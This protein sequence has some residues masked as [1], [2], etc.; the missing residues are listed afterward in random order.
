MDREIEE[1]IFTPDDIMQLAV[2]FQRSRILLTAYELGIFTALADGAKKSAEIA[3]D[4]GADARATDRL[5]N[6]LCVMGLLEKHGGLFS[7]TPSAAELLVDGKPG[8][9]AG[10]MHTVHLW[11][12][13]S[14]LTDAVRTGGSVVMGPVNERGDK[15][16][17][18]FIAAMH[19]RGMRQADAIVSLLD[20][21]DVDRV[22]DVGGGSGAFSIAFVRAKEGLRA[23][24]FDLPNVI[25]L[26]MKYLEVEGYG[27]SI[28]T[29]AGDYHT[30][31]LGTDYD[32]VLFSA[33]IHSNSREE[34]RVLVKNAANALNP[35]GRVVISDFIVDE[36]RAGPPRAVFFALNM[37]VATRGGDTYTE[38]EIRDIMGKAGLT[39]ITRKDTDFGSSLMIGTKEE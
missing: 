4:L 1:S 18:A 17:D 26:T 39:G 36:D 2:G 30:D 33:I 5:M 37:L 11:D 31:D 16:L 34:N 29:A 7:N 3:A 20:L 14:T 32:M 12:T 10:L 8:Y 15:W 9:M 23:T 28:N 21:D 19:Y 6:A 38:S 35:G 13:W 22:L 25:P 24:V 27:G